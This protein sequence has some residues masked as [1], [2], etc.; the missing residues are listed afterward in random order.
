M[1]LTLHY[2]ARS[3]VGLIREGNEDSGYAGPHLLAVADGMGGHA[4]G[5]VASR[6]AIEEL[7]A[8][9]L[10][11]TQEEP[12][13][14]MSAAITAANS[15]IRQLISDDPSREG[16]GTTVTALFW[17]GTALGMAHIGDSRAYLL[18]DGAIDQLSHDHTFVQSLVDEGRITLDE[19]S[20]HPARSLIL[21][22]LQGQT[23]VDPD[24]LIVEVRPGDRLLVCSDGL[25]GVVSDSTLAETLGSIEGL[26]DVADELVRLALAGGAPDNVTLIVADVRET[27]H[28]RSP[29]DTAEAFLVG[30]A[31]GDP[32]TAPERPTR[33]R[34][35]ALRALLGG[36][37]DSHDPEDLE[38]MRYALRSPRRYR[39]VRPVVLLVAVVLLGWVGLNIA[40]Q[41]VRSQ[42]YVGQSDG[43]VAI[44]QGV[45]QEIGPI[46][47]SELHEVPGGLPV[48]ALPVLQRDR[49]ES[50]IPASNVDDAAY[51][52]NSLRRDACNAYET[53]RSRD[54]DADADTDTDEDEDDGEDDETGTD[55]P[56]DTDA[57]ATP[58]ASPDPSPEVTVAPG[59][60]GDDGGPSDEGDEPD[61]DASDDEP[62][63]GQAD[64]G[65]W[66]PADTDLDCTGV[67]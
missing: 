66:L 6:A 32:P 28:V 19:A 15:R 67:W 16:M 46:R 42:Y 55:A 45:S 36:D 41:W 1:P 20:V 44:F 13:D 31:A 58:D 24:L 7:V 37:D 17:T 9:E 38:A 30:A 57:T 34:P 33:R 59:G 39:W 63:A 62:Q 54:A 14:A 21:K 8:V 5:E 35:A 4:A 2:V 23:Q 22:A 60:A 51:I 18:R 40:D 53:R 49:V 11:P 10:G 52:V 12:L 56:D 48:D 27:D 50:T 3:H 47:L 43:E 26:D 25:S 29:D 64:P 61:D 65:G